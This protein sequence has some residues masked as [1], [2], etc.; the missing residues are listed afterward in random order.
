MG[1]NISVIIQIC[2]MSMTGQNEGLFKALL[3]LLCEE[4]K[5]ER[6]NFNFQSLI[7]PEFPPKLV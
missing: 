4:A 6:R 5:S 3:G 2:F 1:K 7:N